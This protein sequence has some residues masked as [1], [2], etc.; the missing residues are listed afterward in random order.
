MEGINMNRQIKIYIS[1][2]FS[3]SCIF[4]INVIIAQEAA[5]PSLVQAIAES[6]IEQIKSMI[7]GGANVNEKNSLGWTPMHAAVR[8]ANIEAVKLI[9]ENNADIN[10]QDNLGQTPLY[11]AV[12]TGQKEVVDLLISKGANVNITNNNGQNPLSL[13]RMV[14]LNTIQNVL[15]QNGAAMPVQENQNQAAPN[16][17]APG[18]RRGMP[19]QGNQF[20]G[21]RGNRSGGPR[22]NGMNDDSMNN[23]MNPENVNQQ[24]DNNTEMPEILQNMNDSNNI[25]LDPNEVKEK[26][27]KYPDL[28][29][30]VADIAS[31]NRNVERQW[32]RIDEDNRT[33]LISV[34]RRQFESEME[35]IKKVANEEK[36]QKTSEAVTKLIDSRKEK[37]A[38]ITR[39]VRDEI[40][41]QERESSTRTTT[42]SSRRSSNR[43]TTTTTT[44]SNRRGG[45]TANEPQG[46]TE[47]RGT[48]TKEQARKYAPEVQNEIDNWLNA[49]VLNIS[50]RMEIMSTVND[51]ITTETNSIKTIATGEKAEKTIAAIDGL[52]V[53]RQ[54]SYDDARKA[55][56]K[57]MQNDNEL[58]APLM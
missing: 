21:T 43:A 58:S 40:N 45:N 36:A 49:D 30:A 55:F 53:A 52:L 8:F 18:G 14:G 29:K 13:A 31:G 54:K 24:G 10:A 20:P 32:T 51:V 47:T 27:K 28:E 33:L 16:Q 50:G 5:G 25:A 12:E 22:G 44:R 11:A 9:L 35:F 15:M 1:I 26:I 39:E 2:L 17:E 4:T 19:G 3:L 41:K 57:E 48:T 38:S 23:A 56:E 6:S 34:T 37:F 46:N 42:T 7:S